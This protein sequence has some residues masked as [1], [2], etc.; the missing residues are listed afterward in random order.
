M[1]KTKWTITVVLL[2][3]ILTFILI[4]VMFQAGVIKW[5]ISYT[6]LYAFFVGTS[7][8]MGYYLTGLFNNE[9][10]PMW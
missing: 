1:T 3:M 7:L 10:V 4:D 9:E 8:M 6:T 5:L 2:V